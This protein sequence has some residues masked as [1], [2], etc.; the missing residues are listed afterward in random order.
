M[1]G[2]L[3]KPWKIKAIAESGDREWQ[4]RRLDGLKE[5]NKTPDKWIL[6]D[7]HSAHG[8][9]THTNKPNS[10][11]QFVFWQAP[12]FDSPDGSYKYIKPRYQVGEVVYI[13]DAY[14]HKVD[15]I[16]AE[17]SFDEFWYRLDNPDVIKVDGDGGPELTKAGYEASP[18][19][20]PL[21]MPAS[22]ARLFIKITDVRAERLQ[23]ITE[24]DCIAEGMKQQELPFDIAPVWQYQ[25]LWD[26]INPKYPWEM[27]PWVWVY[28]FKT[29][30]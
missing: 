26:S 30:P 29:K 1:K 15:P 28:Q 4:T 5:I 19:L 14:C 24:E 3:F 21:F 17:V 8:V 10:K 18:W 13:K 9:V 23:E 27:N 25:E 20:S 22:A 7:F 16:T 12:I 11:G 2:I 6:Y